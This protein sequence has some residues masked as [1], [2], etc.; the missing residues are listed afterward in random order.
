MRNKPN[1]YATSNAILVFSNFKIIL[2]IKNNT[3]TTSTNATKNSTKDYKVQ[4]KAKRNIPKIKLTVNV[5]VAAART[6]ENCVL[7]I[8]VK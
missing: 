2:N 4:A 3:N 5:R 7:A 6:C 1:I 8:F